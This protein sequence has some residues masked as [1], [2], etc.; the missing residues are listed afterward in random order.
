M[1]FIQEKMWTVYAELDKHGRK[2]SLFCD[3]CLG[4]RDFFKTNSHLFPNQNLPDY[5]II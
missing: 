4:S 5:G 1:G 3:G 2:R